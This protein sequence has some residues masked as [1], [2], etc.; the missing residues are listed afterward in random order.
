MPP[1]PNDQAESRPQNSHYSKIESEINQIVEE[2]FEENY[3]N[4]KFTPPEIA[5][6][7]NVNYNTAHKNGV[8]HRLKSEYESLNYSRWNGIVIDIETWIEEY[9]SEKNDQ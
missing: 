1:T 4:L 3:Q 5:A 8:F 9:E 6:Q 7:A 2:K